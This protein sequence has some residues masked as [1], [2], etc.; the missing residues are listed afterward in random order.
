MGETRFRD[1]RKEDLA[2][3]REIVLECFGDTAEQA[4]PY[5]LDQEKL[6]IRCLT[7]ERD[8]RVV[9]AVYLLPGVRLVTAAGA[10]IPGTYIYALGTLKQE[11][12]RGTGMALVRRAYDAALEQAEWV[13]LAVLEESLKKIYARDTAPEVLGRTRETVR[14]RQELPETSGIL[15]KSITP[16][17]YAEAREEILQGQAHAAYA[18]GF[19]RLAGRYGTR[20]FRG[21]GVLAMAEPRGEE[22]LVYEL[23]TEPGSF[24]EAAGALAEALPAER[25]RIR[26]PLFSAGEGEVREYVLRMKTRNPEEPLK[27]DFWFPLTLE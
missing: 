9:S 7:A 22:C 2:V 6:G 21:K 17:S 25:Y 24:L 11:R 15:L 23:L 14:Q 18:P 4:D 1:G 27:E 20:F 12:G 19:W 26:T 10:S 13:C 16:E 8:G 5:I 3:L